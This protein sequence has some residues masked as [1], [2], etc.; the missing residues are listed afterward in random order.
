M[1]KSLEIKES[2]TRNTG[3]THEIRYIRRDPGEK[4]TDYWEVKLMYQNDEVWL[5]LS[6]QAPSKLENIETERLLCWY[7]DDAK[8][9]AP[10]ETFEQFYEGYC[11]QLELERAKDLYHF[12]KNV[13]FNLHNLL[14]E[15][16][17]KIEELIKEWEIRDDENL[18][19]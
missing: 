11:P 3:V 6:I 16:F 19:N 4:N 2:N 9:V 10:Y 8:K 14:K 13:E 1:K 17:R 15:D 12:G 18:Y 5:V 7:F